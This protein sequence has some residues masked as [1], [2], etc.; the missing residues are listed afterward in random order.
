MNADNRL[1]LRD[2]TVLVSV[3]TLIV[4]VM[5]CVQSGFE[6]HA[7][8]PHVDNTQATISIAREAMINVEH[9]TGR[10]P[11]SHEELIEAMPADRQYRGYGLNGTVKDGFV[12]DGWGRPI[13]VTVSSD[14]ASFEIRSLGENGRD[15][16]GKV[17]DLVCDE[18]NY[19]GMGRL[20]RPPVRGIV[21]PALAPRSSTRPRGA[22]LQSH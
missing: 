5:F 1:R 9:R 21:L 17:D 19:D 11:V 3:L 14:G 16:G 10:Y 6:T 2:L 4:A 18:R 7:R 22:E 20:P 8:D 15:D 13:A 12:C